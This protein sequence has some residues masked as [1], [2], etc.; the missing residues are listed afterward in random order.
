MYNGKRCNKQLTYGAQLTEEEAEIR[1][2]Q[3][4]IRGFE[5]ADVDGARETHM[6]DP[7]YDI[8]KLDISHVS[9]VEQLNHDA[10]TRPF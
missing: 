8:K 2:K 5:I 10:F 9:S 7:A 1:I 3:W 4:C 6:F